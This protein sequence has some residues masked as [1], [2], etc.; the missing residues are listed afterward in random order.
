MCHTKAELQKASFSSPK[1]QNSRGPVVGVH[2]GAHSPMEHNFSVCVIAVRVSCLLFLLNVDFEN[3]KLNKNKNKQWRQLCIWSV[4][5][6][7]SS[8]DSRFTIFYVSKSF[9]L[10]SRSLVTTLKSK[11]ASYAYS[12]ILIMGDNG[13]LKYSFLL[14]AGFRTAKW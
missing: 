4:I 10:L 1:S 2:V 8:F 5:L 6:T 14:T 7:V 12:G 3:G 11:L 13:V 9:F